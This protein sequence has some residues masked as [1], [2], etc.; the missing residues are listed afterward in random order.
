MKI[1]FMGTPEFAVTSLN[2][3][4]QSGKHDICGVV[5]IPDKPKGR[6]QKVIP[7]PVKKYAVDHN[8][9]IMQPESFLDKEFIAQL[10]SYHADLFVVVAFRILP[11]EIF[12]IPPIG[13][14]NVHASLL[15]KYRGAAPINWAIING[16][17]ESGVTTMIINEKIDTGNILLQKKISLSNNMT[18]GEL[19]DKLAVIGA[20]LLLETIDKLSDNSVEFINQNDQLATKAPK[21]K[22]ETCHLDFSNSAKDVHNLIRGLSPYPAAYFSHNNKLIK[23]FRN[24][25]AEQSKQ[26]AAFG[27]I[28]EIGKD[29]VRI[30]CG[31]GAIDLL[32]VCLEGKKRTE[33]KAFLNGYQFKIGDRLE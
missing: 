27:E 24:R 32:E 20:D 18:A 9:D 14:V 13:T 15:P 10:K 7:S 3:L 6:G 33:I 11:K 23:V 12:S 2:K 22:K 8:I 19:H 4:V 31:T 16:D 21:I 5:T 1:V 26:N 29:F 25:I 30:Q 17:S 28:I